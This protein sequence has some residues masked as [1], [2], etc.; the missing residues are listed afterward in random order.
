MDREHTLV[1][2]AVIWAETICALT[3]PQCFAY[4]TR[5][6]GWLDMYMHRKVDFAATGS[7]DI[8]RRREDIYVFVTVRVRLGG[9]SGRGEL[10]RCDWRRVRVRCPASKK[11]L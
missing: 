9:E 3:F 5:V 10:E 8:L 7:V 11:G 2:I 1:S 6:S 4:D